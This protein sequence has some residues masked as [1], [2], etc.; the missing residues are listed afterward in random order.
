[1]LDNV[2]YLTMTIRCVGN[3]SVRKLKQCL[4][5]LSGGLAMCQAGLC[6]SLPLLLVMTFRD[7]ESLKL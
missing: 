7:F 1:M 2:L 6:H 5:L 3:F 4:C